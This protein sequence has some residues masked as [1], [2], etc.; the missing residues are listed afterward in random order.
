M[1]VV[2]LGEP[3]LYYL[4]N[5]HDPEFS[6]L[7]RVAA[8][9]D[10]TIDRDANGTRLFAGLIGTLARRTRAKPIARAG[11]AR[12]VEHASRLAGDAYKL[13]THT[14]TLEDLIRE[15]DF[16]AGEAGAALIDERHVDEAI[17][18]RT[19][20]SDRLRERI[21]E[22]IVR[23]T[24]VID[25]EGGRIGEVNGLSVLQLDRFAFG[26]PSRISCRV[27]LGKGEV[28]DIER[29]V[30]LGGPLHAKGVLILS[31]YLAGRYARER[32]LSLSA[33]L[34]FEQS[35]GG[36]E[37]DSASSAEL[38]ALLSAL[39]GIPIRQ[40]LAVTGSVDQQGR[41]QAIGGVNEKIEGFFDVCRARGLSGEQGVLIPQANV[42]NLM[43]RNDVVEA[44]RAGKF[45]IFAV[46]SIDEGIAILTGVPAG[47]ADV[48]GEFPIGSVNRAV[49]GR[50]A[51]F[52]RSAQKYALREK[53]RLAARKEQRRRR[54]AAE[55]IGPVAAGGRR[56]RFRRILLALDVAS[57][58]PSA[59]DR[60]AALAARLHGELMALYVEDI[61]LVRL[62]EHHS[63]SAMST[64]TA[65]LRELSTGRLRD[66]LRLQEARVRRELERAAAHRKVKCAF[67]VRQGRLLAEVLN[68]AADDDLVVIGW[69]GGWSMPAWSGS[70]PPAAV[71]QT[72][73][74]ARA[75]SVLLLHPGTPPGG[76]VLIAFDGSE[77][78]WHALAIGAQ[79][80]ELEN[81]PIE[82]AL[83]AGRNDE[84][85]RWATEINASLAENRLAVTFLHTPKAA[86]STL[87]EI[88]HVDFLPQCGED[89][90]RSGEDHDETRTPEP[91]PGIQ[92]EGGV[93]RREG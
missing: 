92:G 7:F 77:K 49:A 11:V 62:A 75:R 84:A 86:L 9:F 24:L 66:T 89:R 48:S 2:L 44:C 79:I 34:V 12:V 17:E 80:A 74:E 70:A 73:A 20:R 82:V 67:E 42:A 8:D 33:S 18:A 6:E 68:V 13:A 19:F 85:E 39:A 1:K 59:M 72:L 45:R 69:S 16:W 5:A 46:A 14:D 71:A 37:G 60:A 22:Q 90:R 10:S 91:H 78:A 50:L 64:V 58:D 36:I 54:G 51:A 4:L 88:A 15:A 21:Q 3:M 57:G 35:Y 29:E 40:S 30:A 76:R 38:Y 61:D 28:V 55:M 32:P 23:G 87:T 93:G 27:R 63:I 52:L 25:T 43:L 65:S 47:E 41:V 83:L 26:K 56:V 31:S 81:A 53:G